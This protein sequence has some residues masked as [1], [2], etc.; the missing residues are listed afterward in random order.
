M[1]RAVALSGAQRTITRTVS[2]KAMQSARS[3]TVGAG[4]Q[5]IQAGGA[6]GG[7]GGGVKLGNLQ[8]F[9]RTRVDELTR[10]LE[11][12][13]VSDFNDWLV[14]AFYSPFSSPKI[15]LSRHRGLHSCCVFRRLASKQKTDLARS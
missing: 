11:A 7:G 2:S 12:R 4:Q 3:E 14:R 15:P 10:A 6:A 8:K 1:R 5:P 13:A 9:L